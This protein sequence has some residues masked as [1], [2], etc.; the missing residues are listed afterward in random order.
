MGPWL[1]K[2]TPEEDEKLRSLIQ[3]G[4]RLAEI[5][6]KLQRSIS[7]VRTRAYHLRLSF[8]RLKAKGK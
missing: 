2:W 5:S 8:K 3:A 6:V 4:R 1:N 7:A